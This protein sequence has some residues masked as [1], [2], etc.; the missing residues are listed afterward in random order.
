[1][2]K[3]LKGFLAE[4]FSRAKVKIHTTSKPIKTVIIGYFLLTALL[5]ITYYAAWLYQSWNG[6][7]IMSDLL[8][9]IKEIIGPAMVG[10]IT[11]IAGCFIDKDNN[12]IPDRFEGEQND[13]KN[14]TRG[15]TGNGK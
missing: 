10:F 1:M 15:I 11:F 9:V 2:L 5:V 4:V 12:G 3:N 8:A 13:G 6:Q 7:I 14:N